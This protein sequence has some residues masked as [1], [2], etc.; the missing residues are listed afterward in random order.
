MV[1]E[2]YAMRYKVEHEFPVTSVTP[3]LKSFYGAMSC[4][5]TCDAKCHYP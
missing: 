3:V 2:K 4:M 1:T 5:R